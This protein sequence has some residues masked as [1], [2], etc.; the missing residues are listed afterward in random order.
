MIEEIKKKLEELKKLIKE[1]TPDKEQ[2]VK[3]LIK[4]LYIELANN[5]KYLNQAQDELRQIAQDF[6]NQK[7]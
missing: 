7:K 6:R 4:N 3:N 2:A 5:I 1:Y